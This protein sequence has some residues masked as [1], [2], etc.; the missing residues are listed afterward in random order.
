M[1]VALLLVVLAL[2]TLLCLLV[3]PEIFE[4]IFEPGTQKFWELYWTKLFSEATDMEILHP[5]CRIDAPRLRISL[6]PNFHRIDAL[7]LCLQE[8]SQGR[9]LMFVDMEP[10][11]AFEVPEQAEPAL[12]ISTKLELLERANARGSAAALVYLPT[13][14]EQSAL[15]RQDIRGLFSKEEPARSP[16][17][18]SFCV[19]AYSNCDDRFSGV[20][21]RQEFYRRL[22]ERSGH[23]VTN[24]GKCCTQESDEKRGSA[25]KHGLNQQVFRDFK[26][27]ISFENEPSRGYIS[28]KLSNAMLA[29]SVPIYLGAPDVCD[30][31]NPLSFVDVRQYPDLEACIDR[32][33]FLDGNDEAYQEVRR[34]PWMT[35]KQIERHRE[36][37][38]CLQDGGRFPAK[39]FHELLEKRQ[40]ALADCMRVSTVVDCGIT[41]LTFADGKR[42]TADRIL[43]TARRSGYFKTCIALDASMP[44]LR[45]HQAFVEGHKRGHGYWIWKPAGILQTLATLP[46]DDLLIYSDSGSAVKPCLASTVYRWYELLRRGGKELL[47]L[48]LPYPELKWTKMDCIKVFCPSATHETAEAFLGASGLGARGQIG[49]TCLVMKNTDSVRNLVRQ[50]RDLAVRDSYAL[51]DDSPSLAPNHASFREH[52]HDQSLFSLLLKF[53]FPVAKVQLLEDL[54]YP[55]TGLD[56]PFDFLHLDASG[57]QHG[58]Y[59]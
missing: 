17:P 39:V 1:W 22:Q 33:L 30:Y 48:E 28:E 3:L 23:R 16:P 31:F 38:L 13:F 26:F 5:I 6:I 19:F 35:E 57:S 18:T 11:P 32:V 29:G 49:A 2:T 36:L 50:W 4:R 53:R 47:V 37:F 42:F 20:R 12:V 46:D 15:Q 45:E 59:W 54:K 7:K 43:E 51:V 58:K 44:F 41:F 27:T 8:R 56:Q 9:T 21:L 25:E 14:V 24:L 34:Q 55:G 40:T 10:T 52:R